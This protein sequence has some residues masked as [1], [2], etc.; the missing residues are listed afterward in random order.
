M[1]PEIAE[2]SV[3]DADVSTGSEENTEST[4]TGVDGG[5]SSAEI[6]NEVDSSQQ[7]EELTQKTSAKGK[8]DLAIVVKASSEA[9]KAIDPALPQAIQKAAYELGGLYREFPGGLK[10]AVAAKTALSEIGGPEGIK[11]AT[12]ALSDYTGLESMFEK[13]DAQF[14]AR[15]AEAAP[16]SF[17][18]VMPAGLE[19]WK[20]VDPEMYNYVQARVLT[21]T[22][23]SSRVSETLASIWQG[24]DKEKQPALK[25]AVAEIWQLLDGFRKAGDKAPERKTNPEAE[26]LTQREQEVAQ[27]EQRAMLTPIAN[28][29]KRQIQTI[30]DREMGSSYK[31]NETEQ[32]V[33]DAV[34]ERVQKEVIAASKKDRAFTREFDRL[35]ARS[36]SAGL[37][38][39]VKSFQDRVTPNIVPRVARLFNV[40]PKGA[41]QQTVKKPVTATNG[42]NG[43]VD[44]GWVRVAQQPPASQM[45]RSKTSD[46]M[47]LSNR[48]ITKDGK[49]LTWA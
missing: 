13:G 16:E 20:Q 39:H 42:A 29:G 41:G 12:E 48:M 30:L 14:M 8:V 40:K 15:L 47:I 9:L 1:P 43:K 2:A 33:K 49:R 10:E 19:K 18:K 25:D 22:L 23:D 26:K 4:A 46:D 11:E 32:S 38:R 34:S 28:E 6:S 27:R 31:W 44:T 21:Q 5:E 35:V 37:E 24:L 17:S 7:K 3:M 36:D 45:D